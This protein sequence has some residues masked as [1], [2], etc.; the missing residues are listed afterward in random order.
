MSANSPNPNDEITSFPMSLTNL[1]V[2]QLAAISAFI[3]QV[4]GIENAQRTIESLDEFKKA[5]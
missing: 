2:E 4:G 5:A 3:E 1:T